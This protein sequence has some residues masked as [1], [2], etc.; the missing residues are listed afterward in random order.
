MSSPGNIWCIP[1]SMLPVHWLYERTCC[2]LTV[3]ELETGCPFSSLRCLPR[4]NLETNP[5]YKQ[6]IPYLLIHEITS[7]RF[8]C[9][10]RS[11]TEARL[12]DL[13]SVGIGG[14]IDAADGNGVMDT[15]SLLHSGIRREIREE[16]GCVP[17]NPQLL[18]IINEEITAVGKVHIGI[19]FIMNIEKMKSFSPGKEMGMFGWKTRQELKNLRMEHW[20]GLALHLQDLM[21]EKCSGYML[22]TTCSIPLSK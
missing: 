16:L 12:Y 2:P 11:G 13:W 8:A 22:S 10:R 9:Y 4:C 19:V 21:I 5:A 15:M 6:I 1:R 7:G 17:E 3:S 14:H 20:S 18:G